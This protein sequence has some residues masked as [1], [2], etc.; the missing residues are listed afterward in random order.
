MT[1][2]EIIEEKMKLYTE[3]PD[4]NQLTQQIQQAQQ[5]PD[6]QVDVTPEQLLAFAAKMDQDSLQNFGIDPD[7]PNEIVDQVYNAYM[8]SLQQDQQVQ[9]PADDQQVQEPADDQQ[10]QQQP[11]DVQVT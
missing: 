7:N 4:A 10:V 6:Q 9:E 2:D 5:Q 8:Q 11:G 1:F 3:Q